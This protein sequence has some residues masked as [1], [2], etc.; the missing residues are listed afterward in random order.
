MEQW[1]GFPIYVTGFFVALW[2]TSVD[3][4]VQNRKECT[5]EFTLQAV[6][7]TKPPTGTDSAH[8]THGSRYKLLPSLQSLLT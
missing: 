2:G 8:Q 3:L 6:E 7:L 5:Q 1:L 4:G